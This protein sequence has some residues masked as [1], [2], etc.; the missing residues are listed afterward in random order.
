MGGVDIIKGTT[1]YINE[2]FGS[3]RMKYVALVCEDH[4]QKGWR[5]VIDFGD[6]IVLCDVYGCMHQAKYAQVRRE[7]SKMRL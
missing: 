2:A 5:R 7:S 4:V 3:D 1:S 6:A